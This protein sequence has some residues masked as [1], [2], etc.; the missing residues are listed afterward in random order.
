M[1]R[2][3]PASRHAP[4]QRAAEAELDRPA[5]RPAGAELTQNELD[6]VAAGIVGPCDLRSRRS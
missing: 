5:P 1:N 4:R 6:S 3:K 2:E